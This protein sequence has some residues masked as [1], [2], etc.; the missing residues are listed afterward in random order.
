MIW[1]NFC[2][3]IGRWKETMN[4]LHITTGMTR[5]SKMVKSVMGRWRKGFPVWGFNVRGGSCGRIWWRWL[6]GGVVKPEILMQDR[7]EGKTGKQ[8]KQ[9]GRGTTS[10]QAGQATWAAGHHPAPLKRPLLRAHAILH[11][12]KISWYDTF[13]GRWEHILPSLCL[14]AEFY[15]F[16]SPKLYFLS[17]RIQDQWRVTENISRDRCWVHTTQG[18]SWLSSACVSKT[19]F[20][21]SIALLAQ[22]QKCKLLRALCISEN[23]ISWLIGWQAVKIFHDIHLWRCPE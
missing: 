7:L 5:M 9:A 16:S 11:Y 2:T 4:F 8:S 15:I 19:V 1:Q 18:W 6:G 22:V 14:C 13:F 23:S 3:F 21:L 10:R 12:V 17:W 20:T